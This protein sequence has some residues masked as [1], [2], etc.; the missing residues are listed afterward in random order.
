MPLPDLP[1]RRQAFLVRNS[2][3]HPRPVYLAYRA[4]R[5][6]IAV[7]TVLGF[8]DRGL[9]DMV[10]RI[11]EMLFEHECQGEDLDE[12]ARNELPPPLVDAADL[13]RIL[14]IARAARDAIRKGVD[15]HLRPRGPIGQA[16]LDDIANSGDD[17]L[18]R[19]H[20]DGTLDLGHDRLTINDLLMV[21]D[22]LIPALEEAVERGLKVE[23]LPDAGWHASHY[24]DTPEERQ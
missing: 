7:G 4:I 16:M 11:D 14:E 21:L 17:A 9:Y 10:E 6:A 1:S 3:L 22:D 15:E 2:A 19:E 8:G 18:F 12:T 23:L 24:G 5:N 13:P 20:S